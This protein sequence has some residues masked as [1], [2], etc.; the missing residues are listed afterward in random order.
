MD[1]L[2]QELTGRP[3]VTLIGAQTIPNLLPAIQLRPRHAVMISTRDLE[4]GNGAAHP[5]D[6]L[7]DCLHQLGI[8]SER[9]D[10]ESGFDVAGVRNAVREALQR[11]PDAIVNITGGTKLMMLAAGDAESPMLYLDT[12]HRAIH[13]FVGQ[14]RAQF[15]LTARA[16]LELTLAAHGWHVRD[17][18]QFSEEDAEEARRL[19]ETL[20][21]WWAIRRQLA[22]D[23]APQT[24]SVE[25]KSIRRFLNHLHESKAARVQYQQGF[26]TLAFVDQRRAKF[27]A[28]DGWIAAFVAGELHNAGAEELATDLKVVLCVA[29][30]APKLEEEVDVAAIKGGRRPSRANR[31]QASS[32]TSSSTSGQTRRRSTA[33]RSPG[34]RWWLCTRTKKA[35]RAAHIQRR[36]RRRRSTVRT[37]WRR[38]PGCSCTMTCASTRRRWPIFW[39]NRGCDAL[40]SGAAPVWRKW[41][42][43]VGQGLEA[44]ACTPCPFL[45]S[46]LRCFN[47]LHCGLAY[48]KHT[49]WGKPQRTSSWIQTPPA[50]SCHPPGV[51]KGESRG[52][53]KA[54]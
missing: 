23:I 35:F 49:A 14:Q 17:Y 21:E 19:L 24:F 37:R 31:A 16:N 13:V 26:A 30:D 51:Q 53:A 54:S 43:L 9:V 11:H 47:A 34:R 39:G 3:H 46:S 28:G 29:E 10:V 4:A 12:L 44:E 40:R 38:T 22:S 52:F 50:G 42:W 27:Y 2:A 1:Q 48:C 45:A 36:M 25:N 6:C 7:R 32:T 33:D 8:T 15:P 41:A 20:P 18:R 5:A